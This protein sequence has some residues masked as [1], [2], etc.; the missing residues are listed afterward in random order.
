MTKF[1]EDLKVVNDLVGTSIKDSQAYADLAKD[2]AYK[3]VILLVV[4][5]HRRAFQD[6]WKQTLL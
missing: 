1:L 2:S 4:S 6:L 5:D 3:K